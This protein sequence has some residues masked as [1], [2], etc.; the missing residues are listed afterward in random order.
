[1]NI[2]TNLPEEYV[3]FVDTA[4]KQNKLFKIF[5]FLI[6]IITALFLVFVLFKYN[7]YFICI[8]ISVLKNILA[9]SCLSRCNYKKIKNINE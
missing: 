6:A 7:Y 4:K 8:W 2:E 1:M 5:I 3:N 9:F